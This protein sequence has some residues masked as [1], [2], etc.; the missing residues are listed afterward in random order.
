MAADRATA[1]IDVILLGMARGVAP[2]ALVREHGAA[3]WNA[4]VLTGAAERG[5]VSDPHFATALVW[6]DTAD[7][8]V[9]QALILRGCHAVADGE[10]QHR[11]A[12]QWLE[13]LR[14]Q[15]RTFD[16]ERAESAW[17]KI[18]QVASQRAREQ[19]P[20]IDQ[21]WVQVDMADHFLAHL[22]PLAGPA[23][24]LREWACSA[25]C[26]LPNTLR[27]FRRGRLRWEAARVREAREVVENA[28]K[29]L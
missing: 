13:N 17:L 18:G 26:A 23:P 7:S 25:A 27:A 24:K 11:V 14:R 9:A 1:N 12:A 20:G 3:N 16:T 21:S 22:E 10:D 4:A 6:E 29:N 5:L 15:G 8:V 2:H 19:I 28:T